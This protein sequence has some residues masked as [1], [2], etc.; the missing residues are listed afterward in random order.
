MLCILLKTIFL[1]ESP[2]FILRVKGTQ[3]GCQSF[4]SLS[5]PW[6]TEEFLYISVLKDSDVRGVEALHYLEQNLNVDGVECG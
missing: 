5:L 6:I 3:Y 4:R 1:A 2:C